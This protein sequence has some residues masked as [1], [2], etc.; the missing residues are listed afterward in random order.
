MYRKGIAKD[1]LVQRAAFVYEEIL[2]R[3]GIPQLNIKPNDKYVS[4]SLSYLSDFL[5]IKNSIVMPS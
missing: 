1:Q 3:G 2:A 4:K 5:E